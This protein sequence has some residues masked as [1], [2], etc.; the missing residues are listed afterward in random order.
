DGQIYNFTADL[1]ADLDLNYRIDASVGHHQFG[2]ITAR[3]PLRLHRNDDV[4]F[5]VIVP[6]DGRPTD[7]EQHDRAKPSSTFSV[8]HAFFTANT[9]R[10]PFVAGLSFDSARGE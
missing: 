1:R 4:A 2:K 9:V 8:R 6:T 7:Q 3:R 10:N 5:L